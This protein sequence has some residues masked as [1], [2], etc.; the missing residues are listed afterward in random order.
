MV[1][2]KKVIGAAAG[3]AAATAAG[4]AAAKLKGGK[5]SI[6][7]VRSRDDGWA[8]EA[9]GAKQASSTHKNKRQAVKAARALAADHAPSQLV[10]HRA[11][12]SVQKEHTYA[13]ED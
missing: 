3:V 5:H 6:Y 4:V 8:V 2:K 10:I 7:H 12:D 11:D 1:D 9:Q 13:V